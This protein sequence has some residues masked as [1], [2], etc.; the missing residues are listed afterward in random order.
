MRFIFVTV[1]KE[2]KRRFNDPG[3]MIS[4]I[5]IPLAIGFL[6][7]SV[8]GGGGQP[9]IRA[10]L[11][12]TDLDDSFVSQGILS[13]LGQDQI[14][15]MIMVEKVDEET[16]QRRIND[17]DG[18]GHLVIPT[19]F[20]KAWLERE[21]VALQLTVNPSQSISPRL[22]REMLESLLDLG[23]YLHKVFGDSTVNTLLSNNTPCS[24]HDCKLP[25]VLMTPIS[26]SSS[27]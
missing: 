22:I 3:G 7:A 26:S 10:Q 1:V 20:G 18:S 12:V 16:G 21:E 19:G 17:G 27:L 2:M 24:A 23:D 14:A 13:A 15:E 9:S 6:M 25:F 4:A 8:M 11:L 5:M